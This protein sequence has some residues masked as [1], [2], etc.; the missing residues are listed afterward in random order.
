[1]RVLSPTAMRFVGLALDQDGDQRRQAAWQAGIGDQ[2]QPLPPYLA[3]GA[4]HALSGMA[5]QLEDRI[6]GEGVGSAETAQIEND[7]GYVVDVEEALVQYL[8]QTAPAYG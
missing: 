1:M 8:H 2:N 3:Q 7:L 5:L 6:A 4:L